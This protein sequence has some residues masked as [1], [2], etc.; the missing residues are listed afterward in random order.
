MRPA[1]PG[2]A[3]M[4]GADLENVFVKVDLT[5]VIWIGNM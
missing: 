3:D 1:A 5:G 2:G 4:S